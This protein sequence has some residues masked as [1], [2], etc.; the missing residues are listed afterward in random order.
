M[1]IR[2]LNK[3]GLKRTEEFLNL[4]KSGTPAPYPK[5]SLTEP[6]TS[7]DIGAEIAIENRK[8]ANRL[9][10][11]E[12]LYSLFS[13][14]TLVNIENDKG[15]WAWLAL[16]YFNQ[17]CPQDREGVR[18]PK[19]LARW[20]PETGNFRK[21]YRHLLAGPYRIYR[22][23]R[24]NPGLAMIL[25]CQPIYKPGEIVEQILARQEM[26]TNRA[27]VE[28]AT[29]LYYEK[30]SNGPRR[31][32]SGK[33]PGSSRRLIDILNQFDVTWDLYSLNSSDIISMLPEEFKKFLPVG[34]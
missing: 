31:G 19:D 34:S 33:G 9:E 8:F 6:A 18:D 13:G 25:L 30:K 3:E 26:I 4:L 5:E 2:R 23:Y 22:L 20:I 15:L 17:L 7:E 32:A 21:Y 1:H 24:D 14:S 27:V 12:Y 29:M 16:F 28:A 11:A 10:A